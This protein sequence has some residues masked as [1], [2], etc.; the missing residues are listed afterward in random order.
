M[1]RFW[2]RSDPTQVNVNTLITDLFDSD[3]KHAH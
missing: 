2:P 3:A 1:G